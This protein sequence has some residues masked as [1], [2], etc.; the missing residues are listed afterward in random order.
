MMKKSFAVAVALALVPLAARADD[1]RG[2]SPRTFLLELKVSPFIPMI[3]SGYPALTGP[4]QTVFGGG[5]MLLA[6]GE[7]D[8]EVW[9]KFGTISIGVSGGYA[10]KYA[11]A[12]TE[13]TTVRSSES[14]GLH[15]VPLKALLTYRFDILWTRFDIPL[16]PFIKGGPVLMPWWSTKGPDI[17]VANGLR[18]AGYKL[19]L[20]GTLGLALVLD[21]LDRRLARDFDTGSGVNHT[22]IFAEFTIQDMQIF[23]FAKSTL[24]LNLSSN[25][26]DFGIAFE[27]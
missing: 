8:F 26:W 18:G 4:Y 27:F 16:T 1:P 11:K 12:F 10:E 5:P 19:G 7:L 2:A 25:H 24:P 21:F 3:D 23:E 17:E 9:Q 20:S 13:N 14:T 15:V 6:E 22:S